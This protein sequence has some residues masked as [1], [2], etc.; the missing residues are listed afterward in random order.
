M[1]TDMM[2]IA[3]HLFA[4]YSHLSV[5]PQTGYLQKRQSA[6]TTSATIASL[7]N[8]LQKS[9]ISSI[10]GIGSWELGVGFSIGQFD[11]YY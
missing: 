10:S 8:L 6:V 11:C 4:A 2:A 7:I 3:L 1:T 5:N 9:D